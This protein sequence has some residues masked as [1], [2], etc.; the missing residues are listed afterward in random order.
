MGEIPSTRVLSPAVHEGI[1]VNPL[2]KEYLGFRSLLQDSAA[3]V[4]PFLRVCTTGAEIVSIGFWG[5][6][7]VYPT[8]LSRGLLAIRGYCK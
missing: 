1:G 5:C 2:L 3:M 4:S 6:I 8:I 7:A